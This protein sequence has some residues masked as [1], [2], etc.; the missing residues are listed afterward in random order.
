MRLW[1]VFSRAPDSLGIPCRKIETERDDCDDDESFRSHFGSKRGSA[2]KN[3]CTSLHMKKSVFGNSPTSEEGFNFLKHAL[4]KSFNRFATKDGELPSA[5]FPQMMIGLTTGCTSEMVEKWRTDLFSSEC[6]TT[7]FH[8]FWKWWLEK[9]GDAQNLICDDNVDRSR[10]ST[11]TIVE[12]CSDEDGK[13]DGVLCANDALA[14]SRPMHEG[15]TDQPPVDT[16]SPRK[17]VRYW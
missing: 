12:V 1:A 8:T 10:R 9:A 16:P 13:S 14:L 11:K 2:Q 17:R 6:T 4:Q 7:D 3:S 5:L 15:V